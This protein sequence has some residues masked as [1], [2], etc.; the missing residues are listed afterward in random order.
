MSGEE[1]VVWLF[2][3][4]FGLCFSMTGMAFVVEAIKWIVETPERRKLRHFAVMRSLREKQYEFDS[5]QDVP[6]G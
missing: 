1:Q 3:I 2:R 4:A 6:D 5:R